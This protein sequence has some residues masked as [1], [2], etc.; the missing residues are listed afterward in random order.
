MTIKPD[1]EKQVWARLK[2]KGKPDDMV[3]M[4][5]QFRTLFTRTGALAGR[6]YTKPVKGKCAVRILNASDEHITVQEYDRVSTT[7]SR[8]GN[9]LRRRR[10]GR[11]GGSRRE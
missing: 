4:I 10:G 11:T 8:R 7:A 2:G 1:Q 6:V 3:C 5:E 9:E